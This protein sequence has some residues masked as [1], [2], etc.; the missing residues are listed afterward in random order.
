[1]KIVFTE[2]RSS[3][4]MALNGV[5]KHLISAIVVWRTVFFCEPD[6][7][8]HAKTRHCYHLLPN[9]FACHTTVKTTM[10]DMTTDMAGAKHKG[11]SITLVWSTGLSFFVYSGI[12]VVL[13]ESTK[14]DKFLLSTKRPET[15][16]CY[17]QISLIKIVFW[18]DPKQNYQAPYVI[19]QLTSLFRALWRTEHTKKNQV[20]AT[21]KSACAQENRKCD[22]FEN[23]WGGKSHSGLSY[24]SHSTR[25]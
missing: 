11:T 5:S 19:E 10:V 14:K 24:G 3:V 9:V 23:S 21:V 2:N 12:S 17:H 16:D 7:R 25:L 13:T 8:L 6:F 20:L 1:M 22:R 4:R 15:P 18:E